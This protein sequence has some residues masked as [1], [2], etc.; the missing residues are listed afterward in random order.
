MSGFDGR[1]VVFPSEVPQDLARLAELAGQTRRQEVEGL[2]HERAQV[3]AR[4]EAVAEET[5][6]SAMIVVDEHG[7]DTGMRVKRV[8]AGLA[9][10][11]HEAELHD[12]DGQL[13][14]IDR[15]IAHRNV[16]MEVNA[17]CRRS[18]APSG[19]RRSR[20]DESAKNEPRRLSSREP[21]LRS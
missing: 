15:E 18:K 3:L 6:E 16:V 7:R 4:R 10:E 12:L 19:R 9:R 14:E 5:P 13:A 1:T 11:R 2:Q 21:S 8:T 20:N 17:E